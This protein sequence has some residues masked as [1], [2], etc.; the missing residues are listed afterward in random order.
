ME[1]IGIRECSR[2][3]GVS[4]TAVRKA[5]AAERVTIQGRTHSGRPLLGWPLA[6][7]QWQA[8][9]DV[10]MRK[11][12]RPAGLREAGDEPP[13]PPPP[14]KP[15]TEPGVPRRRGRPPK[16]RP[17]TVVEEPPALMPPGPMPVPPPTLEPV[18]TPAPAELEP[19]DE[20]ELEEAAADA[21]PAAT[22]AHP[23][24]TTGGAQPSTYAQAR[25][26]REMYQARLAKLDYEQKIGKLV[27]ADEV[28]AEAFRAA[29]QVR[30]VLLNISGRVAHV[31][32]AETDPA[33]V[34]ARLDDEIRDVLR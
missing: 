21:A 19:E 25:A 24:I 20:A 31:L 13:L 11:V 5:I 30:D 2:R 14:R 1:L 16:N 34:S 6:R 18:L 23:G 32:A 12:A 4:D 9:T 17:V 22:A 26:A 27:P 33:K 28:K 15:P 10:S 29:R 8:N 7:E 3:I